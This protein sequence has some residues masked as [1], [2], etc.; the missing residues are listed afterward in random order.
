MWVN[1]S[2]LQA[3]RNAIGEHLKVTFDPVV[4][5]QLPTDMAALLA[6]LQR[7]TDGEHE[8]L[9]RQTIG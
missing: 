4:C 6:Q 3:M 2:E 1:L 7:V 8:V 5:Q 9:G